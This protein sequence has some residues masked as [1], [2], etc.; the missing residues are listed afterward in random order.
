MMTPQTQLP[1]WEVP[2][3]ANRQAVANWLEC[4]TDIAH[5]VQMLKPPI[6][7]DKHPTVAIESQRLTSVIRAIS[8]PI[9]KLL[10]EANG[11]LLKKA[12]RSPTMHPMAEPTN[13]IPITFVRHFEEQSFAI[14]FADGRSSNI[15]VPAFTHNTIV[16]P[17]YGIGHIQGTKFQL[18]NPFDH[19]A[20]PI[21]FNKWMNSPLLQI[22]GNEFKAQRILRDMANKEG[23]HIENNYPMMTTPD[24]PIDPDDNTL[25]RLAN[26][27]QFG[28]LTYLQ[29]FSL[30]TALY[31]L[32]RTR[33]SL[34]QLTSLVSDQALDYIRQ[35]INDAPRTITTTEAD[36]QIVTGPM[37]VLDHDGKLR[38][39][40]SSALTTTLRIPPAAS[41]ASP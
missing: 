17:L 14:G 10:L 34:D 9:R 21:N 3:N 13:G 26:G 38:G 28:G 29:I 4:A 5:S 31:I 1:A 36:I 11:A 24:L 35:A 7:T 37:A 27:I 23:A 22:D 16:H 25:H 15:T 39:D 32:N 40:Y 2:P 6:T 30:Y 20:D 12:I 41:S 18:F 8:T 19:D 33:A